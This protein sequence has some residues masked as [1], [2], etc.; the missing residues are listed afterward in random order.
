M[1][2]LFCLDAKVFASIRVMK[3]GNS[4]ERVL[5]LIMKVSS[6]KK[7]KE[8]DV[9]FDY[10]SDE[11]FVREDFARE[12]GFKGS[13]DHLNVT[14]LGDVVTEL[15]VMRYRCC[16][17]DVDGKLE[18]FEAYG[19]ET[20]TGCVS[21]VGADRL[22][23]F[24]PKMSLEQIR[25]LDRGNKVDFLIEMRHPSW[26]PERVEKGVGGGDFWAYRGK[27]GSC[28]GGLCPGLAEG[29]KKNQNLFTVN[30]RSFHVSTVTH[31]PHQLEFCPERVVNYMGSS[32]TL[33]A[34]VSDVPAVVA[35]LKHVGDDPVGDDR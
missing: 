23:K 32:S 22:K 11:N 19:M 27:F 5:L 4:G 7:G 1:H 33:D 15:T 17:R 13:E 9:F 31:Q 34:S 30:H 16:L 28:V 26:H 25:M 35:A 29:T 10:G 24:F 2:E 12:M 8:A 6:S 14:T 21:Q 3:V 18:F 20:I